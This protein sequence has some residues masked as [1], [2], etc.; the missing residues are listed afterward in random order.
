MET[1]HCHNCLEALPLDDTEVIRFHA[2][3]A[4]YQE[5][6]LCCPHCHSVLVL[7]VTMA[8]DE[9]PTPAAQSAIGF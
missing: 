2:A 8:E 1:I 5:R 4:S 7:E 3:G 9:H 6:K